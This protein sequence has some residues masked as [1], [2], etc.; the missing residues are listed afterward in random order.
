LETTDSLGKI[1]HQVSVC[2]KCPL[3]HGRTNAVPGEGSAQAKIFFIGEG[4]GRQEDLQGRP[5]CGPAGALLDELLAK[6]NLDRQKV[7][8]GNVVKCRPPGNRDPK[9]NEVDACWSYLVRQIAIIK[10]KIIVCL[11]RHSLQRFLPGMGSISQL[12]GRAFKPNGEISQKKIG[13]NHKPYA[14]MALYH[15]AVGLYRDSMRKVLLD[16]FKKLKILLEK[17]CN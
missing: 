10:P 14:I 13:I 17:I 9:P 11:G 16:D 5:F 1:A 3:H 4:P 12:H 8:I 2:T 15:P 6:I 7:F